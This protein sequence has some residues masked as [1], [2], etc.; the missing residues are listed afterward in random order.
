MASSIAA[1]VAQLMQDVH[2]QVLDN[3]GQEFAK[4]LS[5]AA[6]A[7][8]PRKGRSAPPLKTSF[9]YVNDSPTS[10][11]VEMTWYGEIVDAG[12]P[13]TTR[14]GITGRPISMKA[15]SKR[16]RNVLARRRYAARVGRTVTHPN[17]FIERAWTST[18]VKAALR[19]IPSITFTKG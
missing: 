3:V 6:P 9:K 2:K 8:P 17:P 10:G 15:L 1:A 13:G 12:K 4:A 18:R 5:E 19:Q 14:T 11:H 16:R 7:G